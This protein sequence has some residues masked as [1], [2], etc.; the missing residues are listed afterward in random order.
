MKICAVRVRTYCQGS[1]SNVIQGDL[2]YNE[3]NIVFKIFVLY[4]FWLLEST[5]SF[6]SK[7]AIQM[8]L[9]GRGGGGGGEIV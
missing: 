1:G 9:H 7:D 5:R 4:G 8:Q 2:Y 3:I 6:F